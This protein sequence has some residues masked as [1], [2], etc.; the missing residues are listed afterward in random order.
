MFRVPVGIWGPSV[1]HRAA[2]V[3]LARPLGCACPANEEIHQ[4]QCRRYRVR[5]AV[6][7]TLTAM[8]GAAGYLAWA[9]RLTASGVGIP[10]RFFK[11]YL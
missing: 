3:I 2:D 5:N 1:D 4:Q 9:I 10:S 6:D 8:S 7:Q 11:R